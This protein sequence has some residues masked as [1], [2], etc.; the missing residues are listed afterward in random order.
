MTKSRSTWTILAQ[1]VL[2]AS[3]DLVAGDAKGYSTDQW[4][5]YR[6][7]RQRVLN[8]IHDGGTRNPVVLTGDIHQ[9]YA[10]DLLADFADPSS[11]IVG[12]ELCGTSVTSGGD[13]SDAVDPLLNENPWIK[14][15]SRRRGYVQVTMDR[16]QLRADFRTLSGVTTP[17]GAVATGGAFVLQDGVRGL[18]PA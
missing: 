17:D 3:H 14:Y 1:Q 13:G 15:N 16:R 9:H 8:G 2:M 18:Q 11:P 12:S 5:A 4:D 10:S 6:A 7:S